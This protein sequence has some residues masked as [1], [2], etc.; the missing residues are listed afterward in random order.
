MSKN[1][2]QEPQH[3]SAKVILKGSLKVPPVHLKCNWVKY[4][5]WTSFLNGF[6]LILSTNFITIFSLQC[7]KISKYLYEN[8]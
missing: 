4:F 7:I 5:M 3:S 1:M 2:E 6:S 8:V